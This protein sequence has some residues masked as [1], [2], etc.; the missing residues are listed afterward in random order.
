MAKAAAADTPQSSEIVHEAALAQELGVHPRTL[1]RWNDDG[2]GPPRIQ[3]NKKI[4]YRRAALSRWLE[5]R[6]SNPKR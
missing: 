6:E 1:R 4:I 5:A 2:I 3:I